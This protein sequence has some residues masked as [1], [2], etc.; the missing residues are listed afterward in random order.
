MTY[1]DVR[2]QELLSRNLWLKKKQKTDILNGTEQAKQDILPLLEEMDVKLMKLFRAVTAKN[3]KFFDGLF[4]A[5]CNEAA[6][7]WNAC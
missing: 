6:K 2:I 7:K 1:T 4:D 5:A 3:P